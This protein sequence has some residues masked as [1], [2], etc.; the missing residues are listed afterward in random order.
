[1]HKQNMHARSSAAMMATRAQEMLG[2][3]LDATKPKNIPQG[4]HT[5]KTV[6]IRLFQSVPASLSLLQ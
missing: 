6:P 5:M 4:A 1:M 3:I 2:P